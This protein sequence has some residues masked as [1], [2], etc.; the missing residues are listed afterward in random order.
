[1]SRVD[2]IKIL[3]NKIKKNLKDPLDEIIL[4]TD[5]EKLYFLKLQ[6]EIR[7]HSITEENR[8]NLLDENLELKE[9][10]KRLSNINKM[11]NMIAYLERN[12]IKIFRITGN[13]EELDK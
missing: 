10:L 2:E 4:D 12:L 6:E 7:K 11:E 13:L 8:I 3:E 1:M 5:K 9:K